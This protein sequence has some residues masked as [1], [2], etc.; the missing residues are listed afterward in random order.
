MY[1]ALYDP[2]LA[3]LVPPARVRTSFLQ[4]FPARKQLFRA[5][6]PLYPLAFER[7]DLRAFDT[8]VSS[9]TAWAKGVIVPPGAVH[10]CYINTVSRFV[11]DEARYLGGFGIATLARPVVRALAAWD[12]RAAAAPTR[13]IANSR[14]VADRV[15]RYYGRDAMCC[16]VRS[17]S[18]VHG[19]RR[20]R[21]LR[22]R[23]CAAAPYKNVELAIAGCALAGIPLH[24]RSG[25]ARAA[26]RALAAGTQT[27][28][29]GYIDDR[30]RDALLGDARV[31]I[32]PGEEDF[33]LGPLEAAAAERRPLRCAPAVRPKRSSRV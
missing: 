27:H 4:A 20:T 22:D 12:R 23:H 30:E 17:T 32:L 11:F 28:F 14:N 21:R 3:D 7:F 8:I 29:H 16:R 5:F 2:A 10:V 31:A 33:G 6:A 25:T 15:R 1:T 18:A 9:T 13:F 24:R 19:R 26:L